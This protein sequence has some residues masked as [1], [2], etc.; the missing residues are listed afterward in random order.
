MV[1]KS[2]DIALKRK[3]KTIAFDVYGTLIDTNGVYLVLEKSIGKTAELFMN[4]WRAKQLEYTF[5]RGLM[6]NYV[7]FETCTSQAFDYTAELYSLNFDSHEKTKIIDEYFY[8]PAFPDV[9]P[10]LSLLK[11]M[12]CRLFAFSNGKSETVSKLLKNADIREYFDGVISVDEVKSFKPN[13]AVYSHLLRSTQTISEGIWLIS[14]NP[15]D[16]IGAV[17]NG[18]LSAW[19]Q[20]SKTIFDPWEIEPTAILQ[21]VL[22]VAELVK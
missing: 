4:T 11:S 18:L 15:F 8:L 7:D 3:I 1:I 22:D 21:S 6:Q 14:S 20:R 19:I 9:I 2:T 17:S 12:N 16:V 13:P 5:R 10:G